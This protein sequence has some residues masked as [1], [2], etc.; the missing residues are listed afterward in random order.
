[1][2]SN[3]IARSNS[4][5]ELIRDRSAPPKRVSAECPRNAVRQAFTGPP[6]PGNDRAADAGN[7]NGADQSGALRTSGTD[8]ATAEGH[9]AQALNPSQAG[10]DR[11]N[12]HTA[13]QSACA[14]QDALPVIAGRFQ[15]NSREVIRAELRTFKGVQLADFRVMA[16]ANGCE[17]AT[18]SG[19][20]IG[21][22]QLP[23]L[24]ELV[25]RALT[26]VRARGLFKGRRT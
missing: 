8:E 21:I 1:M 19:F 6:P 4:I 13:S 22:E 25:T 17:I 7:V 11:D 12:S 14:V 20:S 15:K 10:S 23:G 3:P 16:L 26:E 5:K 9:A 18:K 2:G 24:G